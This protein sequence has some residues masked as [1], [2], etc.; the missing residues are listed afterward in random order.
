[1]DVGDGVPENDVLRPE[2]KVVRCRLVQEGAGT[3][4]GLVGEGPAGLVLVTAPTELPCLGLYLPGRHLLLHLHRTLSITRVNHP[5]RSPSEFGE[6][7]R[8]TEDGQLEF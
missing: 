1:V 5:C 6:G 2:E 4:L 8:R 3:R 7:R